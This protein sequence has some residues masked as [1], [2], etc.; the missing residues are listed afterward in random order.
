MNL[1]LPVSCAWRTT[2]I[3]LGQW[4]PGGSADGRN[5]RASPIASR[6]GESRLAERTPAVRPWWRELYKLPP[7]GHCQHLTTARSRVWAVGHYVSA[8]RKIRARSPTSHSSISSMPQ[9]ALV[10]PLSKRRNLRI[11]SVT[12]EDNLPAIAIRTGGST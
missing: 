6:P 9:A 4:L 12:R 2:A 5:R 10:E 11:L 3:D 1:T 8:F 7:C